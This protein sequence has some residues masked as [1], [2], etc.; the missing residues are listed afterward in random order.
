M[1][2][3]IISLPIRNI[4]FSDDVVDDGQLRKVTLQICKEGLVPSHQLYIE[5][6]AIEDAQESIYNK[7]LLCAYETDTDG[8]KTDF[9][10]HEM[11]YKLI[12]NGNLYDLKI[13]YIEQPVGVIPESC[14]VRFETIDNEEWLLVDAYLYAEYCE[15][16]V[17]I[18]DEADGKKSVS[19]EI[20]VI[21]SENDENNIPH[22]NKFV[23]KGVTLLGESR[24]PAIT[25]A[26]ISNFAQSESFSVKFEEL[27]NRVNKLEKG[28]GKVKREEILAKF[29]YLKSNADFE[30]I[31]SN[32]EL[33]DEDLESKLFSLSCNDLSRKIR[34]SLKEITYSY[35]SCWGDSYEY[36]KYWLEDVLF[37]DN[38]IIVEDNEN[39]Y[40][41]YGIPFSIDGDSVKLDVENK[42]RY[43]RGDW[44]PFEEGST[45]P[46]INPLFEDIQS[47]AKE[48]IESLTSEFEVAKG[49]LDK[50]KV[51]FTDMQT[52][53]V[54]LE[55]KV[56][57]LTNF[58]EKTIKEQKDKDI[59]TIIDK[60][61][62]L[63]N[64]NG[65]KEIISNKYEFSTED[66]TNKLKIL[67]FDNGIIIKSDENFSVEPKGFIRINNT[68]S[69]GE[70]LTEAEKRY[71]D[72]VK[73]YMD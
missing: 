68:P 17:R 12:K 40:K 36:Q 69:S 3:K 41:H 62:A 56:E 9:L 50:I 47:K 63:Q 38:M 13:E 25:G 1:K 59:K 15:D 16:A 10:G 32:T 51:D 64:V 39:Y 30:A 72:Y 45:E 18:L 49:E 48:K 5:K 21:E 26:N 4:S 35:T 24:S 67:A 70:E 19:M 8:N 73:K 29:E 54:E 11:K 2:D 44:R 53:K 14:N 66:L 22:I 52:A 27:I 34:E 33:S 43:I 7:P 28:D 31:I 58:Q 71:G 57:E 46:T 23:F 42:V 20:K 65:F 60:F 55:T 37:T 6:S 61:S